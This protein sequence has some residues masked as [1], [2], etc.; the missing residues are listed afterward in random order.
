MA[1]VEQ[2]WVRFRS[3]GSESQ[4]G[5]DS[6]AVVVQHVFVLLVGREETQRCSIHLFGMCCTSLQLMTCTAEMQGIFSVLP[7]PEVS[8]LTLIGRYTFT[9]RIILA[10]HSTILSSFWTHLRLAILGHLAI[11]LSLN[12]HLASFKSQ[13]RIRRWRHLPSPTIAFAFASCVAIWSILMRIVNF[14]NEAKNSERRRT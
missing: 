2:L 13:K 12:P 11:C 7:H 8:S 3:I 1:W 5:D 9:L 10:E 4:V 6:S 14:P